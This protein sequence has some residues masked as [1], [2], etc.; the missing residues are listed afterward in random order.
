MKVLVVT[1]DFP[2]RQGGIETFVRSLCDQLDPA[3][4]VVFTSSMP[5]AT[6]YDEE[7]PFPVVRDRVSMLV[8]TP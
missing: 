8:P 1:N 2:P 4:L 7:L 3:E 5:G 6:S